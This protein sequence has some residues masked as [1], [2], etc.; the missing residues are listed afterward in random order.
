MPPD[1]QHNSRNKLARRRELRSALTPAEAILW[2]A[3]HRSSLDGRKFRRQHGIGPYIVD[4]Y[5]PAEMLIVELEG[6]AHEG[7]LAARRDEM[8]EAFL[9]NR[10]L[11]VLRIENRHVVENLEGVLEFI[12]QHFKTR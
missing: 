9:A 6:A 3:L 8:R 11:T 5:C 10:G 7:E 12:S 4:F 2:G 1:R